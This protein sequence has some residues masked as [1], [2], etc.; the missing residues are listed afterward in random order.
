[1]KSTALIILATLPVAGC[2]SYEPVPIEP[3]DTARQLEARALDDEGLHR[4]ID[5]Y[6]HESPALWPLPRWELDDLTLAA[7]Y[8]HPDLRVARA[9]W[10]VAKAGRITAQQRPNPDIGLSPGYNTDT[11][12]PTPWIVV[13]TFDV[14]LETAGKRGY[15]VAEATHLAEISRFNI[16]S[17]AWQVRSRVRRSLVDLYATEEMQ[18]LLREQQAL[19]RENL[20]LL[21]LQYQSGAISSFELTQA[22]LMAR[23][24]RLALL[25]AER[26][27]AESRVRMADAIGL[28]VP[29][30]DGVSLSFESLG[31]LPADLPDAASRRRALSNRADVLAALSEYAASQAALQVQIAR[32]YP[33]VKLGPGYEYDQGDDKWSLGFSLTLP[34]FNKNQGA[35]AEAQARREETAARFNALQ[36]SVLT[37]ID[38]ALASYRAAL[39]TK[40]ET[41]SMLAEMT[42]QAT[43]ARAMFQAGEISRSELVGIN[44]QL[45]ASARARLDALIQAQQA[46]GQLEDA[47]QVPLDLPVSAWQ[48]E[49][50]STASVDGGS[51]Q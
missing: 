7:F 42:G 15:R 19:Q 22:R 37:E 48:T 40:T 23:E 10:A 46:A 26:R 32:Q 24:V 12:I 3:A 43:R 6:S 9:E 30:M 51:R 11:D 8:Y 20:D 5:E 31:E 1:M 47:L 44:L 18:R 2:S 27:S 33:D 45:S 13:A 34:V 29:A 14:P 50:N 17:V 38:V 16:A 28:A 41:D 35:I 21:E 25:D 49:P 39:H 36:A 4:F